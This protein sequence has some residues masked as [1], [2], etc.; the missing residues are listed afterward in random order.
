MAS[1]TS[2]PKWR[3]LMQEKPTS[4]PNDLLGLTPPTVAFV[5]LAIFLCI[6]L[7]VTRRV[8]HGPNRIHMAL[9][10]GGSKFSMHW[11]WPFRSQLVTCCCSFHS[12]VLNGVLD[13]E[14]EVRCM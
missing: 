9:H 7:E 12:H 2:L 6:F 10:W 4:W 11:Q 13:L 14:N 8:L 1:T 3:P 5:A